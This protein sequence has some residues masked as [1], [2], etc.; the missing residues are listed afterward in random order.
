VAAPFQPAAGGYCVL[1]CAKRGAFATKLWSWN[2]TL[3]QWIKHT[4]SAGKWFYPTEESARSLDELASA[5]VRIASDPTAMV[6]RG[7]LLPERRHALGLGSTVRRIKSPNA[8]SYFEEVP[9]TWLMI[10]VDKFVLRLSDDLADDPE[11][12][13]ANAIEELLPP[14]FHDVRC[15][16][17]LSASAVFVPGILK[18]HVF[19][20][21]TAPIADTLLKAIMKQC[22]PRLADYS[23]FQGVQPH[24]VANPVIQGAPDPLPRRFGWIDGIMTNHSI[25][26]RN[27]VVPGNIP[28]YVWCNYGIYASPTTG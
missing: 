12:V 13:I 6:I 9:H 21:L 2:P 16:F 19:Y 23:V 17:Q 10:D 11:S 27:D 25:R 18:A 15:F 4:Y 26:W 5:I 1:R 22:A 8:D 24:F 14:A 28:V 20:W 3:Q 7:A